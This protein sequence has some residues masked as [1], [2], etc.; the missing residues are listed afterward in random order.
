MVIGGSGRAADILA[1]A[2]R[3]VMKNTETGKYS[4]REGHIRHIETM[5]EESFGDKLTRELT[6]TRKKKFM[7]WIMECVSYSNLITVFDIDNEDKLDKKILSALL[8]G[9]DLTV[10]SQMYLSMVWD[11]VD[12]AEEKVF[13][14]L[15]KNLI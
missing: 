11:R 5:L 9:D 13:K 6:V 2:Q 8:I 10:K 14:S 4:L 7:T 15:P 3:N 12:I 1:Y